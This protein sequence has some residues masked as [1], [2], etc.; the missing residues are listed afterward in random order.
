MTPV[1]PVLPSIRPASQLLRRLSSLPF[2][3]VYIRPI[4]MCSL[5]P[6]RAW[7]TEVSTTPVRKRSRHHDASDYV[8]D[9]ASSALRVRLHTELAAIQ[10]IRKKAKLVAL[11]APPTEKKQHGPPAPR[12]SEAPS[13]SAAS[14]HHDASDYVVDTA[15]SALRVRLHTELAAIQGIRKKAKL[16]A[17]SAPPTEKKQHGPPAPRRSEA[18]SSSAARRASPAP[19]KAAHVAAKQQQCQVT[20]RGAAKNDPIAPN[21]MQRAAE[22]PAAA[23]QQGLVVAWCSAQRPRTRSLRRF[24]TTIGDQ[25]RSPADNPVAAKAEAPKKRLSKEELARA[26]A[27]EESRRMLLEMEKAAPPDQ[28]IYPEELGIISRDYS[29]MHAWNSEDLD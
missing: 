27:R 15:S 7:A 10:G 4:A 9:T 28:T 1:S 14:R 24:P 17:L 29:S 6:R 22:A 26:A 19:S 3:L 23:K 12:R 18:P 2:P 20:Q 5:A 8:V 13:S 16:V 25:R 11:S 21:N